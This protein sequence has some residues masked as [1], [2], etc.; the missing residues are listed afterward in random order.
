M[1]NT[2]PKD[3]ILY[4]QAV[5]YGY[6][7]E[8]SKFVEVKAQADELDHEWGEIYEKR[9]KI[10]QRP[11]TDPEKL[12]LG[13]QLGEIGKQLDE[14]SDTVYKLESALRS[15]PE[16]LEEHKNDYFWSDYCGCEEPDATCPFEVLY[17]VVF[18]H[19]L[20]PN[21]VSFTVRVDTSTDTII[22]VSDNWSTDDDKSRLAVR[23]TIEE[24]ILT[25]QRERVANNLRC[26][27]E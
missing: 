1:D 22:G 6:L 23:S 25:H 21:G 3:P 20:D 7:D 17:T 27:L 4:A 15:K 24:E 19:S 16:I 11:K 2:P 14:I 12:S 8:Y 18:G 5:K 26:N 13:V 10:R 9:E